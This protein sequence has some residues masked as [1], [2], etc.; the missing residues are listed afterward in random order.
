MKLRILDNSIR[1]RLDRSE[2]ARAGRGE[3][4]EGR[5]HF[6]G[7]RHLSYVLEIRE[8]GPDAEFHESCIRL[9]F[10][11]ESV[12]VWS[13]E[14]TAISL[15]AEVREAGKSPLALLVE[16]DFECL[17]PREGEDNS[18]RFPNPKKR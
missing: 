17:N 12:K 2:V 8:R 15:R 13:E 10:P 9:F 14:I 4:I 11:L 16:K 1:L 5:T 18:N 7:G 3:R 6:P